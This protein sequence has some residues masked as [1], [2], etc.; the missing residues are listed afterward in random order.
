LIAFSGRSSWFDEHDGGEEVG[1]A[2]EE[3]GDDVGG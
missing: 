3:A 1:G 2:G